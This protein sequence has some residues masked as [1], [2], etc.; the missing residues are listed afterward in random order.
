MGF[1]KVMALINGL[2]ALSIKEILS[3]AIVMVMEYGQIKKRSKNIKAIIYSIENMDMECLIGKILAN[4][5]EVI[6]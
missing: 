5:L 2:M 6:M 1:L 3:K 4:N